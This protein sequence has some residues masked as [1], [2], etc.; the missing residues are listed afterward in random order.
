MFLSV[1]TGRSSEAVMGM[2]IQLAA[3]QETRTVM[4]DAR[5]MWTL[6]EPVH[7]ISYF[8]DEPLAAWEAAGLRGYWRG[9]FA[10]RAT[11]L[12]TSSPAV[13]TAVFASF[14]PAFVAR[15][16]PGIYDLLPPAEALRIRLDGAVT[17]LRRVL[18]G[19][20]AEVAAAAAQ[21]GAA[22]EDLDCTGRPLAAGNAALPVPDEPFARLWHAATVLR[23]HRGDTHFAAWTATGTDGCEANV[24]RCAIDLSREVLQPIRGW[25]DEQWSAAAS[26]LAERGLLTPGGE[27]TGAGRDLHAAVEAATDNAVAR[28]WERVP[29]AELREL[30]LPIAQACAAAIGRR[31][32]IQVPA[33]GSL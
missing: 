30:L 26:R 11:P 32:P 8:A 1:V 22:I 10:G 21:L 24:L 33:P 14:S 31:S 18:A 20:E 6:F 27:V 3:C 12:R 25:T 17:A 23:E 16:I 28:P 4:T 29:V 7:G 5:V 2:G 19:H 13:V 15:A 9:Y